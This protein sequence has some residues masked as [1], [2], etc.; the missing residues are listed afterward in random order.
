MGDNFRASIDRKTNPVRL[1]TIVHPGYIGHLPRPVSHSASIA[2]VQTAPQQQ[3]VGR[4]GVS[5]QPR[6]LRLRPTH[7]LASIMKVKLVMSYLRMGVSICSP[8]INTA[9]NWP[10]FMAISTG[11]TTSA[12]CLEWTVSQ[13]L[14][15]FPSVFLSY[16]FSAYSL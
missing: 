12:Q 10:N 6:L 7:D 1:R 8:L 2:V 3:W 9:I 11:V 13:N 4:Q 14:P 5:A 16:T 15:F